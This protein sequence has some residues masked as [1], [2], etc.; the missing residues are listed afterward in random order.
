MLSTAG[1]TAPPVSQVIFDSDS[2]AEN[3]KWVGA[4]KFLKENSPVK[5]LS[6]NKLNSELIGTDR[7]ELLTLS[8]VGISLLE[9][10]IYICL[11]N[12]NRGYNQKEHFKKDNLEINQNS[13]SSG[14]R[15]LA[16]V[17]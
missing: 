12:C 2:Q 17:S 6:T 11:C 7:S 3:V 5:R 15:K 9:S 10:L 1:P 14:S 16:N 4:V 13:Y 8:D